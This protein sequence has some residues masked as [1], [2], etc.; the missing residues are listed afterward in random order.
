MFL[1]AKK[2]PYSSVVGQTVTLHDEKGAAVCQLAIMNVR[3]DLDYKSVAEDIATL[4][5]LHFNTPEKS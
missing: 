4:I 3:I 2:V 1:T 5:C